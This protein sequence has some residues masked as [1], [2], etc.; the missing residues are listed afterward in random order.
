MNP[1]PPVTRTRSCERLLRLTTLLGLGMLP[2]FAPFIGSIM[3]RHDSKRMTDDVVSK[4]L[5]FFVVVNV[6]VW[7][8]RF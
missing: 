6:V 7:V 1:A 8:V 5:E 3:I 2:L 4:V